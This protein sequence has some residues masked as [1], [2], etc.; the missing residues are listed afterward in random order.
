MWAANAGSLLL[1]SYRSTSCSILLPYRVCKI[2]KI[3]VM[4]LFVRSELF[5]VQV[6]Q[7][8]RRQMLDNLEDFYG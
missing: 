1:L 3:F 6:V 2:L 8:Q 5:G 4:Q 7:N